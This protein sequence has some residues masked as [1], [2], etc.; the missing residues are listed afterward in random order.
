MLSPMCIPG[1][2]LYALLWSAKQPSMTYALMQHVACGCLQV[3]HTIAVAGPSKL[4]LLAIH[5]DWDSLTD[6]FF[7]CVVAYT[8]QTCPTNFFDRLYIFITI[9]ILPYFSFCGTQLLWGT[10]DSISNLF[11][12]RLQICRGMG[13]RSVGDR[14]K[15]PY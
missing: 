13:C 3:W 2:G 15:V 1:I 4:R 12:A 9:I 7:R 14:A 10:P 8:Q 11:L 5:C 6:V